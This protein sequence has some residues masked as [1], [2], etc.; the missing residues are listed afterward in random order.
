MARPRHLYLRLYLAFL[1]VLV[2]VLAISLGVTVVFGRGPIPFFRQAPRFGEHLARALPPLDDTAAVSRAL[3]QFH[4]ELGIDVV[5]LDLNGAPLA[6]AGAPIPEPPNH[7]LQAAQHGPSWMPRPPLLGAP[8]RPRR[9]APAQAVLIVRLPPEGARAILRPLI[10]L[11]VVLLVSLALVYPLSRSIT[12]PIE[13]LTA[14]AEAFGRGDLSARSG[15]HSDDEVG[16]LARSFDEMAARIQA[17]RRAEKELLANVSHE[18]RTPLAR[19]H[20]ALELIQGRDDD[21]R[22]RL[23]NVGDELDELERLIADIL[24]T[25]RLELA[26]AP[27]QR[28][29]V[30]AARLIEKGRQRVLALEPDR[31]VQSDVQPGLTVLADEGLLSRALDNVLDNARKYGGG[32]RAPIRVEARREN[33]EVVLAV[34]DS[35]AGIPP[36]ELELIFDPFYRGS[37]ARTRESGFGLGLSLARRVVEAHGGKIRASNV[38]GGGARI[39]MRLP[40]A[41]E[42]GSA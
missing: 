40:M 15:V 13:R 6:A 37:T 23:A 33:G 10:W 12:R 22:R 20:V 1:G 29:P 34:S 31:P 4:E 36:Q 38:D 32:P 30:S 25:S 39:E 17:T 21:M 27:L 24:T 2:A 14:A 28:A 5:I 18:L 16:K 3:E 9:G 7:A 8:V 42:L 19:I 26:Q 35:G 41:D 11:A